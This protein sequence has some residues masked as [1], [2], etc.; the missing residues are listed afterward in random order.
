M[1]S[2]KRR[3]FEKCKGYEDAFLPTRSTAYSCGYDFKAREDV[4]IWPGQAVLL[5]TGV[6]VYMGKN[7]CLVIHIR[8]SLGFKGLRQVN[9]TGIIDSDYYNNGENEGNI[10]IGLK[11]TSENIVHIKRGDRV[12][13][14]LFLNYLTTDDDVATGVRTGGVGSTGK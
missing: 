13:Q 5:E 2:I 10:L 8:S 6:K 7:E 9:T 3:G 12:V 14:G 1:K 11:N 4:T